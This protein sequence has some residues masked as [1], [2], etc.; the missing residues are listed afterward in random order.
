MR[1]RVTI[2][3]KEDLPEVNSGLHKFIIDKPAQELTAEEE[4]EMLEDLF[5]DM[6]QDR[7]ARIPKDHYCE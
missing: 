2:L 4:R 7:I 3:T 1:K 6:R 5:E